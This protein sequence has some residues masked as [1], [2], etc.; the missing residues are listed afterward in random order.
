MAWA[1]LHR[2]NPD[3]LAEFVDWVLDADLREG[4]IVL[5]QDPERP[6][7]GA[8]FT[9]NVHFDI[10]L[11][12]IPGIPAFNPRNRIP[13]PPPND[14]FPAILDLPI[15]VIGRVRAVGMD[16]AI[17]AAA[18][19][20]V[21]AKDN[22]PDLWDYLLEQIKEVYECKAI[23]A[24]GCIRDH[25]LGIMP[26]DVDIFID[27]NFPDIILQDM[28]E[29][30]WGE[31]RQDV[32]DEASDNGD[33]PLLK[34][35][36]TFFNPVKGFQINLI[37]KPLGVS[38]EEYAEAV[39]RNFDFNIVKG[40]YDGNLHLPEETAADIKRKTFTYVGLDDPVQKKRSTR[41]FERFLKRTGLVDFKPIGI[42]LKQEEIAKKALKMKSLKGYEYMIGIV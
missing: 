24:G 11:Q 13:P 21:E 35:S 38:D 39:T 25:V 22:G 12:E 16:Q 2:A 33:N 15:R 9:A 29:L 3:A 32:G 5:Q 31:A 28:V 26:K 27:H 41:R 37:A 17:L 34:G 7:V 8:L 23:I 19:N 40:Y 14:E 36:W 30:N 10:G 6:F 1:I 18:N 4:E 20:R 42:Q